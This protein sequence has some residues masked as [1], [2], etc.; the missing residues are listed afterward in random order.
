MGHSCLIES[1]LGW[2]SW[3]GVR[4]ISAE[5]Y[6]RRS[7]LGRNHHARPLQLLS[8]TLKRAILANFGKI[9]I[10][11]LGSLQIYEI[12]EVKDMLNHHA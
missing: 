8:S 7:V 11:E 6:K 12:E 5:N 4:A 2:V 9:Y 3:V 1:L 10:Y